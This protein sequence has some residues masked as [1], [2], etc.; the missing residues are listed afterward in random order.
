MS[1]NTEANNTVSNKPTPKTN[2][3]PGPKPKATQGPKT[4]QKPTQKPE[5]KPKTAQPAKRGQKGKKQEVIKEQI[6]QNEKPIEQQP[7]EEIDEEETNKTRHFYVYYKGEKLEHTRLSGKRPK[8]AAQKA[9]TSIIKYEEKQGNKLYDKDIYFYIVE[10]GR[11]KYR[12]KTVGNKTKKI[13]IVKRKFFYKGKKEH[14]P[15]NKDDPFYT[16]NKGK[17]N[18]KIVDNLVDAIIIK[19]KDTEKNGQIV[20]GTEVSY[21]YITKV[22][23]LRKEIPYE[24]FPELKEKE[25]EETNEENNE[26]TTEPP[27]KKSRKVKKSTAKKNIKTTNKKTGPKK[28]TKT[29]TKGTTKTRKPATPKANNKKST[30]TPA[31]TTNKPATPK[32]KRT[33]K[34]KAQ[35]EQPQETTPAQTQQ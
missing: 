29:T 30:Q 16:K 14:I 26:E 34:P 12:T 9:L 15:T 21:R 4:T 18:L 8:Q 32:P 24:F 7:T 31:K 10:T 28:G 22:V 17:M 25:V 33:P 2:Q 3:K 27:A 20:P 5:T 11:K 6:P 19:R 23:A 13:P 35:T 1:S